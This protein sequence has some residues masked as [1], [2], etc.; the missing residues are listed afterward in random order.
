M[1]SDVDRVYWRNEAPNFEVAGCKGSENMEINVTALDA[2]RKVCVDSFHGNIQIPG[3]MDSRKSLPRQNRA[4]L[5]LV[6]LVLLALPVSCWAWE[7]KVV[8]VTDGDLI[9]VMHD[10]REERVR[11]YGIDTPD[12]PQEFGKE[13]REFVSGR[14]L[15]K[16]VEVIPV[17]QD[18]FGN[19][20]AVVTLGG[21]ALNRDLVGA[22]LAWVYSGSCTRSECMEWRELEADARKRMVGLWSSSNPAPPWDFRRSGGNISAGTQPGSAG[23]ERGSDIVYHADIVRR[24]YH[25]PGCPE[26]NCKDCIAD[27]KGKQKAERAGYKPCPV[28]SP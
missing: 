12:E 28:C 25:A 22:G 26:Y 3:V 18:R 24:L 5:F 11:L 16:I 17:N 15:G 21:G 20:V 1:G 4:T 13:A 8:G 7:G 27:F 19:T 23:G 14:A 6:A 9:T 2:L 10:G